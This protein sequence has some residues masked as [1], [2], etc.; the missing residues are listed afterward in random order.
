MACPWEVCLGCL[1]S[2]P[3]AWETPRQEIPFWGDL[4]G[5]LG[6]VLEERLPW[7]FASI[8]MHSTRSTSL[9]CQ[10]LPRMLPACSLAQGGRSTSRLTSWGSGAGSRAG[11]WAVCEEEASISSPPCSVVPE[12]GCL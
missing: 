10:I 3:S 9:Q 8:M 11:G 4:K 12:I 6:V 5:L 1:P 7:A 2:H